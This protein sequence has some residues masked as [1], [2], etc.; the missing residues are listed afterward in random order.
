MNGKILTTILAPCCF[1]VL[2]LGC[3]GAAQLPIT[4][5]AN[6]YHVRPIAIISTE[7]LETTPSTPFMDEREVKRIL[8]RQMPPLMD[9]NA[10]VSYM[11]V[12]ERASGLTVRVVPS[13]S[14]QLLAILRSKTYGEIAKEAPFALE[15]QTVGDTIVGI[16][17]SF[18]MMPPHDDIL[19]K[20]NAEYTAFFMRDGSLVIVALPIIY[21]SEPEEE[22]PE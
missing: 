5:G 18:N 16:L 3:E 21:E 4:T 7:W 9:E 22:M 6:P 13:I 15:T 11:G 20:G 1:C 2:V 14:D 17:G 8:A 12:F 10:D 19:H